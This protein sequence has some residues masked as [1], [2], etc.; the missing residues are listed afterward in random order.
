MTLP[1]LACAALGLVAAVQPAVA[2]EE[3]AADAPLPAP[4]TLVD[5]GAAPFSSAELAHALLARLFPPEESGPPRVRIEPASPGAVSVQ[6]G[7]RSRIVALGDRTGPAAARVVALVVAELMSDAEEDVR[8]E[9]AGAPAAAPTVTVARATNA[10]PAASLST[11]PAREVSAPAAPPRLYLTGGVAKGLAEE[12]KFAGTIDADVAVS[13]GRNGWRLAPSAGFV[14]MPTRNAGTW[15]QVSYSAA[16]ARLLGGTSWGA[17][18]FFGGPFAARYSIEGATAHA[19]F[20]F[21]AEAMARLAAP[22]S[23]RTR[24]VVA[25]RA[26]V[27]GNRVRVFWPDD[28]T[29]YATPRFELT[30]GLGLAWDWTS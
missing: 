4:I 23:R 9:A 18:E 26:N 14:F 24:L 13:I 29:G 25:T 30:I 10:P 12:E 16:V 22:L 8:R 15:S 19:G 1:R 17:L 5:P 7:D 20:L 21:G 2:E 11:A 28:G 6:V 3:R 27:Y